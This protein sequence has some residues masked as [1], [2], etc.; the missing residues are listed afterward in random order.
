MQLWVYVLGIESSFALPISPYCLSW[1]EEVRSA[2]AKLWRPRLTKEP[3]KANEFENTIL[4]ELT[5][6]KISCQGAKTALME[7]F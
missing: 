6:W 5:S 4:F 3:N 1:L 7:M 2:K